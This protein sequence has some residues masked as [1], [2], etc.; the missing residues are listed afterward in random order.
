MEVKAWRG[1]RGKV[2][3]SFGGKA[4]DERCRAGF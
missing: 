3:C 2:S 4:G 1:L